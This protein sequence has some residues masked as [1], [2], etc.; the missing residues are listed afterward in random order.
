MRAFFGAAAGV[1]LLGAVVVGG[2]LAWESDQISG[3]QSVNVGE[4][5]WVLGYTPVSQE[6]SI[7][8][9]PLIQCP[10]PIGPN[11][12]VVLIG[13]VSIQNNGDFNLTLPQWRTNPDDETR[14]NTALGEVIVESVQTETG[15][16]HA[17]CDAYNFFGVV[18][19]TSW[20]DE[21]APGETESFA[22]AV[23]MAVAE[24]APE[25]CIEAIVSYR[26]RVVVETAGNGNPE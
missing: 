8:D 4:L 3:P 2:T 5:E 15:A 9:G 25:A 7:D 1:A 12:T 26:V 23:E 19:N 22:G 13:H 24:E 14:D 6:C 20:D 10:T 16:H 21:V 11:G 18:R 17:A